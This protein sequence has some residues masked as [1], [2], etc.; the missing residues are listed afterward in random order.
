MRADTSLRPELTPRGVVL[1]TGERLPDGHSTAAR[2]FP[3]PMAPSQTDPAKLATA[4]NQRTLYP[5][6]MAGYVKHLA[7]RMDALKGELPRRFASLRQAAARSGGHA[8]EPGQ[9]AHLQLAL[10]VW[11]GFAVEVRATTAQKRDELLADSW[12]VLLAHAAEHGRALAEETPVRLFLA[13]LGDGL[14]GRKAYLEGPDGG[15]PDAPERWGWE[16]R[17][18]SGEEYEGTV[19]HLPAASLLGVLQEEWVL[20]YPQATMQFVQTASRASGRTFPV[21]LATLL[22]RLDEAGLIATE[23]GSGRRTPNVRTGQGIRRVIKLRR[24]ALHP[25]YGES[26]PPKTGEQ[27]EHGEQGAPPDDES[28][29]EARHGVPSA[30]TPMPLFVPPVPPVPRPAEG[31]GPGCDGEEVGEWSA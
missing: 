24:V 10:E 14:A 18:A 31:E 11:L 23:P 1:V 26:P 30:A 16:V 7:G 22:R 15:P 27:R 5:A 6:A 20:L 21:E 12:R 29:P 8:R 25:L 13:L 2:M 4:Q 17:E 28:T 3:V 19:R 9:V